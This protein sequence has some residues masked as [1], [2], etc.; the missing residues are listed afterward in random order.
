L[1]APSLVSVVTESAYYA[2]AVPVVFA[3]SIIPSAPP[4]PWGGTGYLNVVGA[5]SGAATSVGVLNVNGN[6]SYTD[7]TLDGTYIGSIDLGIG[8]PASHPDRQSHGG[9]RLG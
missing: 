4:I 3:S 8:M 2:L 9:G 1:A 7:D 5:F 6:G